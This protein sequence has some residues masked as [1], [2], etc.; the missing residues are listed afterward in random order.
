MAAQAKR[1]QACN[2]HDGGPILGFKFM[3]APTN[4]NACKAHPSFFGTPLLGH[5]QELLGRMH[6]TAKMAPFLP[7]VIRQGLQFK[8]VSTEAAN[9]YLKGLKSLQRYEN[10]FKLFWALCKINAIGTVSATTRHQ[11]VACKRMQMIHHGL[12][13]IHKHAC[14]LGE[15]VKKQ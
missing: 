14:V 11:C 5:V 1:K 15:I 9:T 10:A 6:A 3:V 12:V 7:S 8:Q 2:M 13:H 4:E